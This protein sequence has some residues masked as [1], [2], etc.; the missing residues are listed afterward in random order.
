MASKEVMVSAPLLV[1]LYDRTFVAG[2]FREA[3]RWRRRLYLGLAG[4]W[5]LLGGLAYS[6]G[7]IFY[8]IDYRMRY[9]HFIWHLFVLAG[10]V[11]H[12]LAVFWYAA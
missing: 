10:T 4:S 1:L 9:S 6:G 8:A 2:S 7:V 5:I 11:L 3:W 12:F